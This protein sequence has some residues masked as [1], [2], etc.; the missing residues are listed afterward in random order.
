M[1]RRDWLVYPWQVDLQVAMWRRRH[2]RLL[3]T[4]SV[5]QYTR[6]KVHALTVTDPD[7]PAERKRRHLFY[8]PHAHEPAGTAACLNFVSQL[9]T[10]HHLDGAPSTIAREDILGGAILTFIPDANPYGRAR[11]PEPYWDGRR[12]NNREFINMVFG[13]GDLYSQEVEKPRWERYKRVIAFNTEEVAPARIGLVYEPVSATEY[14]EP[15]RYDERSSLVR[16]IRRLLESHRYDQVLNLHQTEFEGRARENCMLIAPDGLPQMPGGKQQ[17]LL[18]WAK[19]IEAT[20]RAVD[21]EPITLSVPAR[22][23]AETGVQRRLF[24]SLDDELDRDG[25]SLLVEIQNN[26]PRTPAE[27]QLL[28]A[29]AAIWSSVEFLLSTS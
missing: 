17:R 16:L 12:Y 8:V 19:K 20:W 7:V 26:S 14:V 4:D 15:G 5:A 2:P 6:H 29:D 28:L 24:G 25:L 27:E 9:L 1:E 21:G 18:A 23:E 11:C 10:G 13:I 3:Q 22:I